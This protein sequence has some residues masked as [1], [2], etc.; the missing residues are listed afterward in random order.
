MVRRKAESLIK[1]VTLIVLLIG[2]GGYFSFLKTERDF[3]EKQKRNFFHCTEKYISGTIKN[4]KNWLS[5]QS[6]IISK[7]ATVRKA[8]IE[9]NPLLIGKE[10]AYFWKKLNKEMGIAEL[11]FFKYPDINFYSFSSLSTKPL[12]LKTRKDVHIVQDALKPAAYF[13]ICKR[14]PG[15][16]ATYPIT[17]GGK[18]LGAVS[19][20]ITVENVRKTLQKAT[21]GKVF[22]LLRKDLMKK[23]LSEKFYNKWKSKALKED[24]KFFYY[25]IDEVFPEKNIVKGGFV[26]GYIFYIFYPLK[27]IKGEPIGYIGIKRSFKSL[28]FHIDKVILMITVILG[29]ILII[30]IAVSIWQIR[31]LTNQKNQI[32]ELLDLVEKRKFSDLEKRC[33]EMEISDATFEEIIKKIVTIGKTLQEYLDSIYCKL[34]TTSQKALV[35]AL[36]NT[37]NRHALSLYE[38]S[39]R[40]VPCSVLMIDIDHFKSIN[41]KF[42]HEAGD[43]VLEKLVSEIKKKIRS[44][45]K[46]FRYGGEEFVVILP[47]TSKEN[48]KRL[49]ERIRKSIEETEIEIAEGKKINITASIGVAEKREGDTIENVI[50][51]ADEAMYRAKKLGRNRVSD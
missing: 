10:F 21:E 28:F 23:N 20:G 43:K 27:D 39:T 18:V 50:K 51:R 7:D 1:I 19:L 33:S 38:K 2:M 9:E 12:K 25:Q 13:Y 46:L 47:E 14:Y 22:Y 36:T 48:A 32:L 49:A 40:D 17:Y 16:R 24:N 31:S 44:K 41:D 30:V 29:I 37:F 8:Y 26:N 35:D 45:D 5:A 11:H 6:L 42:G 34:K 3:E 15:L 4:L